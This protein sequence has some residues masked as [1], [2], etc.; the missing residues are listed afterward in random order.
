[1]SLSPINQNTTRGQVLATLHAQG[2]ATVVELAEVVGVK[3]MTVRH[4]LTSLQ[5]EGLV[6]AEAER[7]GV[8]RPVHVYRLTARGQRLFPQTYPVLID[9]LLEQIK[10]SFSP[11]VVEQLIDSLAGSLAAQI[12]GEV[13]GLPA[14]AR[15]A[16]LVEWLA[17][18]GLAARWRQSADGLQLV[19]AH[20]PY[21]D[22]G[23]GHP[24]LCQIDESLVRA[25]LGA[26]V[27]R[28]ACLLAGDADCTLLL[29][30]APDA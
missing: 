9:G 24:E 1:M 3:A 6:A 13:A 16:R 17:Q 28:S 10:L 25:A 23:E 26:E 8:G 7:H 30:P 27:E 18:R 29:H 21:S 15:R 22:V 14:D 19:K 4:H 12:R 5:A 2:R 20:C 11:E